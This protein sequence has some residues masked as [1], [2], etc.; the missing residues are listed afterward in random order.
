[1]V[2]SFIPQPVGLVYALIAIPVIIYLYRAGKFTPPVQFFLLAVSTLLGF[3]IFAPVAPYQFQQVLLGEVV[4]LGMPLETVLFFL[5]LFIA[6]TFLAGRAYCSSV[7]PIGAIQELLSKVPGPKVQ[8]PWKRE[9]L[10]VHLIIGGIFAGYALFLS[11]CLFKCMGIRSFFFLDVTSVWFFLFASIMAFGLFVY[12]P[13][14]RFICPYGLLL[15]A[16][17]YISLFRLNRTDTCIECGQ[18]E[19]ICPANEAF[20][21]SNKSECFLCGRCTKVCPVDGALV[22]T[23]RTQEK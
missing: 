19:D 20:R 23:R 12:R 6:V 22:Y 3:I 1:M 15:T 17:S 16:A 18:C 10:I 9:V 14:C 13:F 5:I 4:Q 8:I 7:C 2:V 11:N 21:E